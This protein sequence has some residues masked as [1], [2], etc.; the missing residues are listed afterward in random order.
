MGIGIFNKLKKALKSVGQRVGGFM[1][2]AIAALPK[3]AEVGKKVVGAVSPILSTAIPGA[4]V[5][6]DGI[7]RGLDYAGKFGNAFGNRIGR[8]LIPELK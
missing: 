1:T 4:G 7:N 2:K 5:V 6:L 3:V 8:T